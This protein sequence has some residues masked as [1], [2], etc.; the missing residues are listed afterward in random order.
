MW[1]PFAQIRSVSLPLE[2]PPALRRRQIDRAN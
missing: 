2:P 1:Q